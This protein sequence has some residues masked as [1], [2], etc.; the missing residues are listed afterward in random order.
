MGSNEK[1]IGNAPLKDKPKRKFIFVIGD[2]VIKTKH[3]DDGAVT[4]EKLSEGFVE[5]LINMPIEEIKKEVEDIYTLLKRYHAVSLGFY[6]EDEP[7]IPILS[8][9]IRLD[10]INETV[11][12]YLLFVQEDYSSYVTR[13]EWVRESY[14]E[15]LDNA[16]NHLPKAGERVLHITSGD[17][18]TGWNI[19]GGRVGF[20]CTAYIDKGDGE[21][22]EIINKISVV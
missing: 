1:Y 7:P 8:L 11:K 3:L 12:P 10:N 22:V 6:T 21:V 4:P 18:P 16:W 13:W 5:E 2:K 14:R 20:K 17:L 15:D 9:P 19:N